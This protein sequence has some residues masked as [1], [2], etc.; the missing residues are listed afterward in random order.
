M[1]DPIADLLTRLRNSSRARQRFIDIEW[2]K[3][4]EAIVKVLK[5]KGFVAQYLVKEEKK[6]SMMRIFLKYGTSNEPLIQE[7]KR[8]SKPSC[9]HYISYREIPKVRGGI[10]I[11]ILSTPFGV[12]EGMQ[13]R[14][15]KAGGE[16]LCLV[17]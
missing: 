2:S 3:I 11:A 9:R 1:S 13:A 14:E 7:L 17:Y 12:L 15:K 8:M 6:K 10:G 4:K 5:E 16:L